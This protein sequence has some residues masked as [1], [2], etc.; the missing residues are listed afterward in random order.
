MRFFKFSLLLYLTWFAYVAM[1]I[2]LFALN[3]EEQQKGEQLVSLA[4]WEIAKGIDQI[5]N[6]FPQLKRWKKKAKISPAHIHYQ[7]HYKE[8]QYPYTG[9]RLGKNGCYLDIAV[10]HKPTGTL[11]VY[12]FPTLDLG[13]HV[14]FK[15]AGEREAKLTKAITQIIEQQLDNLEMALS[16]YNIDQ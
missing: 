16:V 12:F 15:A 2:Q 5:V 9:Y 4:M 13:I 1:P 7:Y 14:T 8:N 3:A 6:D 11:P 10:I